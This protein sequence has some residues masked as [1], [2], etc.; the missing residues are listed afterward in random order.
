MYIYRGFNITQQEDGTFRAVR[1]N[2]NAVVTADFEAACLDKVDAY[3][4][5]ERRGVG[6]V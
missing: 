4:R 1:E 5:G 3:L 2:G 6:G